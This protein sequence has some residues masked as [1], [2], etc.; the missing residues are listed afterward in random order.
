MPLR[1]GYQLD[2]GNYRATEGVCTHEDALLAEGVVQDGC[3]SCPRHNAKY[4]ICSGKVLTR[5]GRRDL[6]TYPV[7]IENGML[8]IGLPRQ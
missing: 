1:R 3:I 4:D 8:L 2:A 5:P 7:R 6:E